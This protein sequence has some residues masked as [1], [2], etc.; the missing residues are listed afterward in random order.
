M[1][2]FYGKVGYAITAQTRPDIWETEMKERSYFG[3]SLNLMSLRRNSDSAND[4][5]ELSCEI[6]IVADPFAFDNFQFIKYVE[7]QNVKW[8]VKHIKP[9]YPRLILTVGGVYNE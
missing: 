2:K 7:W 6:S 3:D 5:V 8:K 9:Q 4:N 1:G